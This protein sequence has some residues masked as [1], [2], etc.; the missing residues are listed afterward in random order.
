MGFLYI[1]EKKKI[2]MKTKFEKFNENTVSIDNLFI[3]SH[4]LGG[5]FGGAQDYIVIEA[6]DEE[7]AEKQAYEMACEDYEGYVGMYGL[8]DIDEI[9]EEDE[10]DEMEAEDIYNDDRESWLDYSVEKWSKEAE[11]NAEGHHYQND[12]KNITG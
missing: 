8:R 1:N 5:G 3:V 7:D 6:D 2:E 4:G 12:Y 11:K 9:M 10:V